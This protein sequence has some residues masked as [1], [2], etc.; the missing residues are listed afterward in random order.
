MGSPARRKATDLMLEPGPEALDRGLAGSQVVDRVIDILEC[1]SRLGP[2]LGVSDV[3]RS[4]GLKKATTHRLL[5]S[6][7]R[8][9]MV[10]QDPVTRRYR[11]GMKLWELEIGRAH[12]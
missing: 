8:R 12:V 7:L 5:A 10:A 4:L 6:L 11:L 3:S 9:G 2:E 1:F